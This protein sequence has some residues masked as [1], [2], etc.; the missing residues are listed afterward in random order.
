MTNKQ[1]LAKQ[2]FWLLILAGVTI[3]K[4]GILA[5]TQ[6][7]VNMYEEVATLST[8]EKGTGEENEVTT[9]IYCLVTRM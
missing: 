7:V 8:D 3:G 2:H 1:L 4:N 6:N 5:R 9:K